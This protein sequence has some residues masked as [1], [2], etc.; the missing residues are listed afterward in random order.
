MKNRVY[1]IIATLLLMSNN[2]Y[3]QELIVT[4]KI[5]DKKDNTLLIGVTV[6]LTD[7]NGEKRGATTNNEGYFLLKDVTQGSYDLKARYIGYA[8]LNKKIFVNNNFTDVGI[9][10][11]SVSR[12]ALEDIVIKTKQTRVEVLGDTTQ[13]NAD[14]YKVNRD[15]TTEDLLTKMPGVTTTEGTLK[16]NGED[17]KEVLVDGKP[18][19]GNDPNAAIKNLPAEV[20]D[21]IQVFNKQSDQSQFTGFDDGNS[22]KAINIITKAGKNNG[23]FGKIYAGYGTDDRYA[24]GGNVNIFNGDRRISIIGMSNNINQQNFSNEDLL[25][26]MSA[27]SSQRRGGG[28]RPPRRPG[29]GTDVSDFMVGSQNGITQSNSIGLN[30]SDNWGKKI[31]ASGSYFYN[32]TNN[33]N[34][35]NLNRQYILSDTSLMYNEENIAESKNQNHRLNLRVEYD[36]DSNNSIIISPRISLQDN[37][38]TSLL[39]G[40][41]FYTSDII[42]SRTDNNT[43]ANNLGYNISNDLLYRHKFKKQGRTLSILA[44]TQVNNSNGDGNTYSLNTYSRNDSSLIDQRYAKTAKSNTLSARIMY[45]EP[46]SKGIQL[47][48]NYSP[49]ITNNNADKETNNRSIAEQAYSNFD[50]LLSNKY[51]STYTTHEAGVGLRFQHNRKLMGMIGINGQISELKGTQEFPTLFTV[52]QSFTNVL[53]RAFINYRAGK[54]KNARLMYHAHTNAPTITQLQNVVDNSNPLLLTTGNPDLKQTV[55]HRIMMHYNSVNTKSSSSFFAYLMANFAEDYVANATYIPTRDTILSNGTIVNQ[56]SQISL[57]VNLDGYFNGKAFITYGTPVSLLKSNLNL[58]VGFT[59]TKTPALINDQLNLSNNYEFSGGLVVG[60]NI[61]EQVDF[62]LSYTGNYNI[63]KNTLQSQNDYTYYNQI[64]SLKLNWLTL[65]D[66]LVLNTNINHSLYTGMTDG[67]NQSFFLWNAYVGYKFLKD[68]S[69][70]AKISVYDLLNQ[71]TNVS[72]TITDTYIEDSYS[73]VLNRYFMLTVT[74][75]LRNFKI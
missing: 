62:T 33:D 51:K 19:F 34:Q 37:K 15:A 10:G 11:M 29:S 69:L 31:K 59:Y 66:R 49:S 44:R 28:G 73:N 56:G 63:A 75:T 64:T 5:V 1:L 7:A 4:G 61:S 8:E 72:R 13:I 2:S 16:V 71:N 55:Q 57:P 9:L 74:Y 36:I 48:A 18:F 46:I 42:D 39:D 50:T 47:M 65:K 14:A 30:Y 17:V 32:S 68:R 23:Q 60:S 52:N 22:Q 3:A 24:A 27:S 41:S 38:A 58:N 67:F 35:T 54:G 45:T 53:P 25:G 6:I 12:K 40:Y 26:V 21:K 43:G 20:I 70:E